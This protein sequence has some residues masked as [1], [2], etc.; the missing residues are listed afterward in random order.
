MQTLAIGLRAFYVETGLDAEAKM[1]LRIKYNDSENKTQL[2][3][4]EYTQA[5]SSEAQAFRAA[6]K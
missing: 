5:Y 6:H 4:K 1:T 3:E 2:L